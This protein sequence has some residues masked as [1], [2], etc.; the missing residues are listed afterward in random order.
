[1]IKI[2]RC[3]RPPPNPIC[4]E[5]T[6]IEELDTL[7]GVIVVQKRYSKSSKVGWWGPIDSNV[8]KDAYDALVE[9]IY[10]ED[11]RWADGRDHDP[12]K[13]FRKKDSNGLYPIVNLRTFMWN[14]GHRMPRSKDVLARFERAGCYMDNDVT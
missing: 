6:L 7:T 1:M 2:T 10:D 9:A 8:S 13:Y 11:I 5:G 14:L 3:Y 12:Y 4:E